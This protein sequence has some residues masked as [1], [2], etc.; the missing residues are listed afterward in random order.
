MVV[1][2][3]EMA[4]LGGRGSIVL[5]IGFGTSAGWGKS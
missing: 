1:D 5:G 4:L 2:D 3:M